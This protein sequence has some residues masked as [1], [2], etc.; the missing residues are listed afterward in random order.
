MAVANELLCKST[1]PMDQ[2]PLEVTVKWL[3]ITYLIGTKKQ[4]QQQKQ[5]ILILL[6]QQEKSWTDS[7]SAS[8]TAMFLHTKMYQGTTWIYGGE[9]T[10]I[11]IQMLMHFE[12]KKRQQAN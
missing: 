6:W 10:T 3:C 7:L 11:A 9:Q 12:K 1:Y 2:F 4:Q 5:I 8:H